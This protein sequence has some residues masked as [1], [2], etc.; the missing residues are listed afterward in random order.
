MKK[1]FKLIFTSFLFLGINLSFSAQVKEIKFS[2]MGNCSMC[3]NRIESA[4]D[5]KGIEL[6]DWDIATK[7]CSV[8][9]NSNEIKEDNIHR[10]IALA[11]HDTPKYKAEDVKYQS[12]KPCCQYKRIYSE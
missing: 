9:F 2:V 10:I 6:A 3:E 7:I 8:T 1:H 12:L 5:I 11:G 4:L